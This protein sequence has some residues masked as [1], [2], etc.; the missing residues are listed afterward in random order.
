M[1]LKLTVTFL[2]RSESHARGRLFVTFLCIASSEQV[3]AAEALA[4]GDVR[5]LRGRGYTEEGGLS[6]VEDQVR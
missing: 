3:K 5:D 6:S 1:C 2:T 4:Q